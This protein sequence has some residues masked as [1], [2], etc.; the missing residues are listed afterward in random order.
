MAAVPPK[1][2]TDS[3]D[4]VPDVRALMARIREQVRAQVKGEKGAKFVPMKPLDVNGQRRAGELLHSEELRFLNANYQFARLNADAIQSH[5]KGIIGKIIVKVKRKILQL[6]W[7]GLLKEYFT[8]EREYQSNLVRFLNDVAKYT[9][10]RD[11]QNF[12][13]L[14]KKIDVDTTKAIERVERVADEQSGD[15]RRTERELIENIDNI[16]RD[17]SQSV[18]S[19]Q[20]TVA[21]HQAQL[22]T[23]E[24]VAK[25]L[26]SI[27]A[28]LSV[29]KVKDLPAASEKEA[30]DFSAGY[31]YLLLENR[32]RGS[33]QEISAR[34]QHYPNIF[35]GAKAPVLEIGGGRGELQRLFKA[36]QI[37][38]YMVDMDAAMVE[39]ALNSGVDAKLGDGISHL[40]SLEDHSL[41]GV[42]ACQV[43]E[44]LTKA[45]LEDLIKLCQKKVVSG[46][47]VVFETINPQSV[48]A[49]SSN[50]FRD[51][52]HVFPMH[53]DTLGY[54]MELAGFKSVNVSYLSPVPNEGL[55][56]Q[57]PVSEYMSPSWAHS[58]ELLNHNINQ[59]NSLLYGYQE[60]Y[61]V[62][63]V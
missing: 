12:W 14:V 37:N 13:E 42:I 3:V 31:S 45:Q 39:A 52:T 50:Y 27:V 15:I 60:F 44:H 41:S 46:G 62:G 33:E 61:I 1:I 53:P 47:K 32:Y 51:L 2:S 48:L 4:Q 7:D 21:R 25:G 24:S 54:I 49:L 43:V 29:P 11:A 18:A 22:N 56:R 35:T 20:S 63:Q 58:V 55:L 28:R 23:V 10:A 26:E 59:L 17:L 9:D 38:S 34:M 19:V 40:R 30:Q 57:I 8:S 6:I 36:A 5:R 16:R